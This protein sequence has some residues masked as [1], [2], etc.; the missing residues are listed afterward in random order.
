MYVV[1]SKIDLR[2]HFDNLNSY[3]DL[4]TNQSLSRD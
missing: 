2:P 4:F 1:N 3:Q